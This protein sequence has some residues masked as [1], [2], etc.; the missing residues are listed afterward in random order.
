[1]Q[2]TKY[3]SLWSRKITPRLQLNKYSDHFTHGF[4]EIPLSSYKY[5]TLVTAHCMWAFFSESISGQL[6]TAMTYYTIPCLVISYLLPPPPGLPRKSFDNKEVTFEHHIDVEHSLWN[7]LYFIVLV[8][9]KDSTEFTGPESYVAE[10]MKVSPPQLG[11][12]QVRSTPHLGLSPL[13]QCK[14]CTNNV[15]CVH[16]CI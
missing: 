7:Y 12:S 6:E 15:F 9:V 3:L 5:Y 4:L 14:A 11:P 8:K 2:E 1:M 16:V 10:M 13:V